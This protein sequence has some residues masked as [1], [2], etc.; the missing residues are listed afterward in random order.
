MVGS[1][2]LYTTHHTGLLCSCS[3][4]ERGREGERGEKGGR[5]ERERGREGEIGGGG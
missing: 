5:A 3:E 2:E 4:R 1:V